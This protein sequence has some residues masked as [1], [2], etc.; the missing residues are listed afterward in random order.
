MATESANASRKYAAVFWDFGGVFIDSP[1]VALN[2]YEAEHGIP[3]DF[4]RQVNSVDPLTNAWAQIERG[5]VT[6]DEFDEL[7]AGESAALGHRIPGK[8]LLGLLQGR[9]RPEMVVALD[10]IIAAGYRTA[11]LTNN[12]VSDDRAEVLPIMARFEFVVESS[13]VGSRKPEPAFY[14][15]ACKLAGVHAGEVVYLDDLGINCKP[16]R[17]LGMTTIKVVSAEQAIADLE[18]TLDLALR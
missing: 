8:D 17:A 5:D 18:R 10:R 7:F 6:E 4:I 15:A 13:K 1:F 2:A 3:H 16:A 11:C 9:V 14:E 12:I